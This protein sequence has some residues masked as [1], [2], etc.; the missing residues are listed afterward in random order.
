MAVYY[1][2]DSAGVRDFKELG[3]FALTMLSLLF[4]NA[5]VERVFSQMNLAKN[6]MKQDAAKT[7]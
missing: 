5:S 2:Q 3:H 6:K 7:F 4:S 1:H